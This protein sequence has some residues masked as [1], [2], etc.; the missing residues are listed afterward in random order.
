[1]VIQRCY[2]A[3]KMTG[4]PEFNRP[5]F[6]RA[7]EQLRALGYHVEN[8]AE[9][10]PIPGDPWAAYMRQALAMM[11]RCDVIVLLPGWED[12]RGATIEQRLA[13]DLGIPVV[14]LPEFI[15]ATPA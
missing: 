10:P 12:S 4:L 7:A 8:P 1:M 15:G 11:L 3:G 9:I 5:A 14:Q 6:N 2:I 13:V